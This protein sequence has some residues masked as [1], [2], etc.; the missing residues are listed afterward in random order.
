MKL[1]EEEIRKIKRN[2]A[3]S[4][5]IDDERI[6]RQG[7]TYLVDTNML[8]NLPK[9]VEVFFSEELQQFIGTSP[10]PTEKCQKAVTPVIVEAPSPVMKDEPE[11]CEEYTEPVCQEELAD[12]YDELAQQLDAAA[13]ASDVEL[14][15]SVGDD[16]DSA[17]SEAQ[18]EQPKKPTN[19]PFDLEFNDE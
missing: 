1:V 2:V 18:P 13:Q 9:R 4:E 12:Q 10:V 7:E 15:Q 19:N 11:V 17:D 3:Q 6:L 8:Q 16:E 14:I 5:I